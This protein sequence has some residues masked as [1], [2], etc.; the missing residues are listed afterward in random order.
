MAQKRF[1][2][3]NTGRD[4]IDLLAV[5]TLYAEYEHANKSFDKLQVRGER[6]RTVKLAQKDIA[7]QLDLSEVMVSRLLDQARKQDVLETRLNV[8]SITDD[9]R[10]A[11]NSRV[12]ENDLNTELKKTMPN[13][14]RHLR[15]VSIFDAGTTDSSSSV[16]RVLFNQSAARVFLKLLKNS[17]NVGITWGNTVAGIFETLRRYRNPIKSQLPEIQFIPLSGD[18][19]GVG[20]MEDYGASY[21][22]SAL[23]RDINGIVNAGIMKSFS[24]HGIP[25]L[26]PTE[27]ENLKT[28]YEML[29]CSSAYCDIFGYPSRR[30]SSETLDSD[31]EP[32]VY[33]LDCILTSVSHDGEAWSMLNDD[34][35]I[36][37]ARLERDELMQLAIG[38][39]GGVLMP[40][41]GISDSQ[42]DRFVDLAQHWTGLR[43]DQLFHCAKSAHESEEFS[44]PGVVVV[45]VGADKANCVLTALRKNYVNH[46]IIDVELA[47]KLELHYRDPEPE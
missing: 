13:A 37:T 14:N 6:K 17:A 43:E 3:A 32:K 46:L 47:K 16:S 27:I 31:P 40:K 26:I 18:P 29:E 10:D 25:A 44:P 19:F 9:E 35:F 11:V 20:N 36:A 5:A 8:E 45:A 24:L 15:S 30:L 39:I 4:R 42:N 28:I 38:D 22:S 2:Y 12:H 34:E 33:S 41:E 7:A 1:D 23:V 21:S